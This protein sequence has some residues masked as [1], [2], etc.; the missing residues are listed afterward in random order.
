M[1]LRIAG[2]SGGRQR[3]EGGRRQERRLRDP[4]RS[5]DRP[6]CDYSVID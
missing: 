6:I 2:R 4:L 1:F 3:G 5:I